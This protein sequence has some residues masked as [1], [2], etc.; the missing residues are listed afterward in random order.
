MKIR[1]KLVTIF[2]ATFMLLN[3]VIPMLDVFATEKNNIYFLDNL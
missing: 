1:Y 3:Y 2:L